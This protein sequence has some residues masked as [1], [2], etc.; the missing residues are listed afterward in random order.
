MKPFSE[1]F[2]RT[3]ASIGLACPA[4]G[5]AEPPQT[6]AGLTCVIESE[7]QRAGDGEGQDPDDGD[8]DGDSALRAVA[9]VVEH[10]HGHSRVP[11]KVWGRGTPHC[12]ARTHQRHPPWRGTVG[13][14]P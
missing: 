13:P 14:P 1:A 9:R 5:P 8:H 7:E 2:L 10:G 3:E 4:Q 11:A 12:A 6:E